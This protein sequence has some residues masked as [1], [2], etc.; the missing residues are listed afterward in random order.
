MRVALTCC[1]SH[2]RVRR[3][4]YVC[5]HVHVLVLVLRNVRRHVMPAAAGA[6]YTYERT[7]RMY[8][9]VTVPPQVSKGCAG[10]QVMIKSRRFLPSFYM[11]TAPET[12]VVCRKSLKHA[13]LS[14]FL[15]SKDCVP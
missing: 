6:R 12:G 14:F 11:A 4:D 2:D 8:A 13:K 5:V 1:R 10:M 15:Q 3:R 9:A 7:S